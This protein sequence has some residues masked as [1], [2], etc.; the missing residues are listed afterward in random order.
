MIFSTRCKGKNIVVGWTPLSSSRLMVFIQSSKASRSIPRAVTPAG[1][2]SMSRPKKRCHGLHRLITTMESG[3]MKS[4]RPARDES[5]LHPSNGAF[6]NQPRFG[7]H[8]HLLQGH[9]VVQ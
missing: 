4:D 1:L 7:Q 2:T 9:S 3:F 5:I 6:H 8:L